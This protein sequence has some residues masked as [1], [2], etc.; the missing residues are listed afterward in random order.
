VKVEG[1]VELPDVDEEVDI[2]DDDDELEETVLPVNDEEEDVDGRLDD[3]AL[4]EMDDDE[5]D[6]TELVNDDDVD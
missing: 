1:T 3:T 6:T 4:D 5:V 2:G